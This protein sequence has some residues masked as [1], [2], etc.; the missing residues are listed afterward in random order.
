MQNTIRTL[1]LS[2]I[3]AAGCPVAS[4]HLVINEIM[5]SN[6]D[7]IMD[8]FNEFPD[9]WVELYNPGPDAVNLAEYSLGTKNK[10]QKAYRLPSGSIPAG[11]HMLIYCDKAAQGR[12]TDFRLESGK[13]G[14]VYLFR[15]DE[16]VDHLEGLKKQPAPNIAY[17]RQT[18]N[19][20]KWG[21]QAVPSP[22]AANC[23]K[24]YKEI[25]GDPVFSVPG[26]VSSEVFDLEL[27]LPADAPE[28]TVI[29]YTL[30]GKE[31]TEASTVYSGPIHMSVTRTVR[32]KL[33]CDGYLSPRSLT[34]SYI[35][36]PR[37]VTLPVVSI[38]TN[39]DYF[40]DNKLGIYVKGNYNGNTPN[41]EYD[42]R[43]PVNY[44]FFEGAD[45]P[46][47]INQLCETRVKGG[48]TR[49]NAL[50]SLAVYANKRFGE[51]RFNYEFFPDQTPGIDEF[52]SFEMRN[53]GNDFDY[54]YMRDAIIQQS[55]GMN[56]DLDWQPS[57]P[58]IFYINGEYKGI[59][60]IRPR[61]N[62]DY[63]YSYYDGLEDLDM[64]E[65]WSELKEGSIDSFNAFK[66]F[67]EEKG[68]SFDEFD[69]LMDTGEFCNLMIMGIF[70]DNKDFPGNNIVMWR[71]QA[72]G[73]RWRWVAKDTD[74][75]MGLY[76]E[77]Y[78]YPTLNWITTQGY[79][80][81][82]N[83]WAN[84][85]EHTR[86]FRNLLTTTEFKDMFI[87][88]CSVY[89]GDFLRPEEI[90]SRI[91]TRYDVIKFEYKYHRDQFN[92]WWPNYS[93]EIENARNWTRQR[94]SFFY[95]HLAGFFGLKT[96]VT[97]TIEKGD[98]SDRTLVVNGIPLQTKEFNG[99]YFPERT[100]TV[101]S[102]SDADGLYVNGWNVTVTSGGKS[103]TDTYPTETL[104]IPMPQASAVNIMPILGTE[105]LS[106]KG[107]D[108]E[109][110]LSLPCDVY[111]TAGRHIG[112]IPAGTTINSSSLTLSPGIYILRQGNAVRKAMLNQQN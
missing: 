5:Q 30:D 103:T 81:N 2:T 80:N 18:D 111:D 7:C 75:G 8:D 43:R 68:H 49:G 17:G 98:G 88:R 38:V 16:V 9:S 66:D 57:R 54:M 23:G 95:N 82:R 3:L 83:D 58:A 79:D 28:G 31:P 107:L 47:S 53:S 33:F 96:P 89:L 48:A 40:Y 36:H 21:Y 11:K 65:N 50:K 87:D 73:G 61:S 29:R 15:N 42:W 104:S 1:F 70:F 77:R 32:A 94:H 34:H 90:I 20:D 52:K 74:F 59:L 102:V 91:D 85:W 55:M 46:S 93:Q 105:P 99:K 22:G 37:K 86:L 63:V 106:V 39:R 14:A 72:D 101:S 110:D 69:A 84:K 13:D 45:T 41:Y 67:Y 12:H 64:L 97:L 109:I 35:K 19:G 76:G 100:L 51:K 60:N 27:S 10:P 6:I 4:A 112:I 108:A 92:P 78:N 25:L 56:C 26:K 24:T 62:E 71:P 44:E